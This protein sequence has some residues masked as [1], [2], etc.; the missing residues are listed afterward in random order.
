MHFTRLLHESS[1]GR[2]ASRV[3]YIP[4]AAV[5]EGSSATHI[6]QQRTRELKG[7][8]ADSVECVVLKD[9]QPQ[10]L[11]SSLK[12]VAA[13]YVDHGNTFYLMHHMRKSGFAEVI[14]RLLN[15]GML[16]VG[17]S[18]STI[19]A[20]ETVSI[21][22]WKGWDNPGYGTDWDLQGSEFGYSGLRL[23]PRV[24]FFPHYSGQWTSL[25][26]DRSSN[27]DHRLITLSDAQGYLVDGQTERR[28]GSSADV[29]SDL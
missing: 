23:L 28:I 25:V 11:A 3:V 21:A 22:F 15:Q 5:A 26:R 17:S 4:D 9:S 29:F 7:L 27:M 8:G 13:V 14:P 10:E 16:Y 1:K 24:S 19:C 2:A 6:C 18:A 12:G 20:G